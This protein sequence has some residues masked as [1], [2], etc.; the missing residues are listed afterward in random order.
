MRHYAALSEHTQGRLRH[1]K[2]IA[3]IFTRDCMVPLKLSLY[4]DVRVKVKSLALSVKLTCI[5]TNNDFR[6]YS[7]Q[8]GMP[9]LLQL[10]H[11]STL[12]KW[13]LP[14]E[15]WTTYNLRVAESHIFG[16]TF[17]AQWRQKYFLMV[18]ALTPVHLNSPGA[19]WNLKRGVGVHPGLG[20]KP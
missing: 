9:H 7:F 4:P 19:R 14:I 11:P 5:P 6:R 8:I 15:G 16:F 12:L 20:S 18:F 13:P 3:N 2:Y 1:L 17:Q 10:L